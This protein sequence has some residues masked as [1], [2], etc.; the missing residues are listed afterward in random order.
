L[1]RRPRV[2]DGRPGRGA[3]AAVVAGNGDVV[4]LALRHA[5]G[6]GADADLGNELDG[7]PRFGIRVF[8]IVDQLRQ[9]LDRIDVVVRRRRDELDAG[10]RVAQLGNVLGHLA[11]GEL[12]ALAGL[13]ALRDLDLQHLGARQVLGGD[14]EAAGSDLLD[15]RLERIAFDQGQVDL[16]TALAE[17]RLQRLA[18]LDRRVAPAVLPLLAVVRLAGDAVHGDGERGVGLGRA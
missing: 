6:N 2:L 7:D 13:R 1:P 15:L 8:Q 14:A 4:R 9:V 3:R 18:G 12:A 5:R 11:P 16:D 10:G 17:P